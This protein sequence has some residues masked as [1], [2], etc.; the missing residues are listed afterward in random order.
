MRIISQ[1]GMQ[2]VPYECSRFSVVTQMGMDG[3]YNPKKNLIRAY[4]TGD[5]GMVNMAEY[6][7]LEKAIKELENI[8]NEYEMTEMCK[9]D[10]QYRLNTSYRRFC[11]QLSQENDKELIECQF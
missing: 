3:K 2:D 4:I 8:R 10:E 9:F 7:T 6:S 11:Y 1:D 5:A